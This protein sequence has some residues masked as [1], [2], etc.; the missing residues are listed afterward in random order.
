[1]FHDRKRNNTRYMKFVN[2]SIIVRKDYKS[3]FEDVAA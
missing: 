2:T 1:M 3:S